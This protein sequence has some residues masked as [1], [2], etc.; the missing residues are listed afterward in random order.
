M[1]L[2]KKKTK[3]VLFLGAPNQPEERFVL[4]LAFGIMCLETAGVSPADIALYIDGPD[5]A[6]ILQWISLGTK[7]A[8]T[9]KATADFF[10]DQACDAYENLMMFVTG[11]GGFDGIS[12]APVVTPSALIASLKKS[13]KLKNAVVYLGQCY[14]GIFNYMAVA[15]STKKSD[16]EID[17]HVIVVGATNLYESISSSTTETLLNGP[18][19]WLANLFL[20]YVFKW[21]SQPT[22]VDGDGQCTVMDSYK[23]AGVQSNMSNKAVKAQAFRHCIM[24]HRT[25]EAAEAQYKQGPNL[26]TLLALKSAE[27]LYFRAA[28]FHAINQEC[29]ILNSIPAQSLKIT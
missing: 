27:A 25:L 22:D 5:R 26:Q 7:N 11:H 1:P 10:T 24:H 2:I 28:D 6:A 13:P 4:D 9:V 15:R 19:T 14:A 8:Y 18:M 3:W 17:P 29:W 16:D 20:L 23:F 21:I 12:A